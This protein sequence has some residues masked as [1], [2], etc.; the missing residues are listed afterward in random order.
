MSSVPTQP[1]S[2][3]PLLVLAAVVG[4]A[5]PATCLTWLANSIGKEGPLYSSLH[6]G[7][8]TVASATGIGMYLLQLRLDPNVPKFALLPAVLVSFGSSVVALV[9]ACV[10]FIQ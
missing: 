5:L 4:A 9:V 6:L 2:R 1:A 10:W 3:H 7:V 8:L